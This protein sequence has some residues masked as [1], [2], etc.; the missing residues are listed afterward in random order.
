M[1]QNEWD[2]SMLETF[3]LK[4]HYAT[5]RQELA[6]ALDLQ[7]SACRVIARLI[8]ERDEARAYPFSFS[9]PLQNST[10]RM[11]GG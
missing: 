6:N 1:F 7:D 3:E 11:A 10:Q 2:A 5:V 9:A 4:K 8:K